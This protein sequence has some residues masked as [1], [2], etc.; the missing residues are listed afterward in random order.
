VYVTLGTAPGRD[1]GLLDVAVSG[2]VD[3]D[4]NVVVTVGTDRDPEQVQQA[5]TN[6]TALRFV[7]QDDLLPACS[8]VVCHGG[9]GTVLGALAHGVPVVVLPHMA[10][11]YRNADAI[12]RVGCGLALEDHAHTPA[13]V[14]AAVSR[15]LA[16]PSLG[17]AAAAL[18]TE[19]A[20]MPSP[21]AA[22]T[23]LH[24]LVTSG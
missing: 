13:G 1:A 16:E 2:L 14:R 24:D 21:A 10:D 3:L 18:R 7:P 11:Q 9:S 23:R 15:A 22:V 8:L 6:V 4:V 17:A 20:S 12:R 5:G 19:I